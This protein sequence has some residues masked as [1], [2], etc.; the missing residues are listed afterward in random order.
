MAPKK[1]GMT[2][3]KFLE[4]W[5]SP[6]GAD[7]VPDYSKIYPHYHPDCRFHDS[8]QSFDGRD[9][10][11]EMCERL[12]QRCAEIRMEVHSAAK[13]GN[14]FLIE[15]TM[16]MR[17]RGT[18]LTPLSGASRLNVDDDGLITLHRDYYDLWGDTLDVIPGVGK[19]FRWFMKTVMG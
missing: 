15:W 12:E 9:N 19:A 17:F 8:I 7:P 4:I 14:V 2:P 13:N 5:N 6:Y 10:F 1:K 3:D 11:M 16:S 18:P